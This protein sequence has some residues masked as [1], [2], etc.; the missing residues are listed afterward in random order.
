M[1]ANTL[2][3]SMRSW[4]SNNSR[5]GRDEVGTIQRLNVPGPGKGPRH[6]RAG[7]VRVEARYIRA[8]FREFRR[9]PLPAPP[10]NFRAAYA[11][12]LMAPHQSIHDP[13]APRQA[14]ASGRSPL[15]NPAQC[16]NVAPAYVDGCNVKFQHATRLPGYDFRSQ[17][18]SPLPDLSADGPLLLCALST[19]VLLRGEL[20]LQ[21]V[22]AAPFPIDAC[23]QPAQTRLDYGLFDDSVGTLMKFLK[24]LAPLWLLSPHHQSLHRIHVREVPDGTHQHC[25]LGLHSAGALFRAL[26]SSSTP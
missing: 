21:R 14:G 4:I 6:G 2:C 24:N 16:G 12:A 15:S 7:G 17:P 13:A 1:Q 19:H 20:H 9:D 10:G 22:P 18:S 26:F 11:H 8:S 3:T 5:R 25:V 23:C